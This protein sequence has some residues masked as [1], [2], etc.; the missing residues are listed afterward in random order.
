MV[1][2]SCKAALGLTLLSASLSIS[3]AQS[4]APQIRAPALIRLDFTRPGGMPG[5]PRDIAAARDFT[6]DDVVVQDKIR[7]KRRTRTH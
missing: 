2:K 7:P 5:A 6:G 4:V 3:W 1:F